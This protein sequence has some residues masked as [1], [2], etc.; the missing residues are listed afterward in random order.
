[1]DSQVPS[2]LRSIHAFSAI[3][4]LEV[5]THHFILSPKSMYDVDAHMATLFGGEAWDLRGQFESSKNLDPTL[6]TSL[7]NICT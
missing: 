4:S 6:N 5:G 3:E 2:H 1:M 7:T